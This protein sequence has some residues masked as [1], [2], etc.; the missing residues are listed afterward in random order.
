MNDDIR[1]R[2]LLGATAALAFG[3]VAALTAAT[4]K[5][6]VTKVVAKKF[7][8]VPAEIH[9][10]EGETITLKLSAPEVPR[11]FNLPDF[12]Q[13]VDIFPGRPTTLQLT[14]DKTGRLTF[15]CDVFCGSGHE[16]MNGT[17]IVT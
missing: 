13:R 12:S 15:L 11:G 7:E 5:P 3:S 10:K 14:P 8:F 6:R 17:L 16:D 9:V 4:A 2:L 1:R